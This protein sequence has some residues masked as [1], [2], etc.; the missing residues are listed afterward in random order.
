[1]NDLQRGVITLIQSAL[2]EQ[3]LTLPEGFDLEAAYPMLKAHQLLSL[4]YDGASRCGIP[5]QQPAM[6]TLFHG[7]CKALQV[8]ERQ[9]QALAK[10]YDAFEAQGI[11]HMP[12]KGSIMKQLYPR[13]ELRMMGDADILIRMDQYERIVPIVKALG[14]RVVEESEYDYTWESDELHLELHKRLFPSHDVEFAAYFGDG[15]ALAK[16]KK[17]TRAAMTPEDSFIYMFTHFAKHFRVA[18]VGCRQLTDLW[19]YL[20]VNPGMDTAYIEAE[21]EKLHLRAFYRNIQRTLSWWFE[22]GEAD[23]QTSCISEYVFSNGCWGTSVNAALSWGVR[24]AQTSDNAS[25]ERLAYIMRRVFPGVETMRMRYPILKKAPVLLPFVWV[26]YMISRLVRP[27][28]PW[29]HHMRNLSTVSREN[30]MD[31]KRFMNSIG[32]DYHQ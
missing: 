28:T 8:S 12:L 18:G 4:A 31:R 23:E 1:M 6:Q 10:L 11:D 15:W 3:K 27:Y 22:G 14:F 25:Y 17:G 20:R 9:L 32:L 29:K 16:A 2:T 26:Y 24:D 13:P 21:L 30:I 5:R 19:V 7:Y